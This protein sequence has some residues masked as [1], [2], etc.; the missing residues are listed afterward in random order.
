MG[1]GNRYSRYEPL[2]GSWYIKKKIGQG[3]IGQVF[4]IERTDLGTTYKAAL[5]A[6][7][8]ELTALTRMF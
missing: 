7:P 1:E 4:E 6:T 5:K 3:A 8:E 2:F